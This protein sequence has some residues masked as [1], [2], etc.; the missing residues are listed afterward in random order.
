MM[1]SQAVS[2]R[3]GWRLL[4]KSRCER[5]GLQSSKGATMPISHVIHKKLTKISSDEDDY[6]SADIGHT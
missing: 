4:S 3:N 2:E 6:M 1:I 5:K